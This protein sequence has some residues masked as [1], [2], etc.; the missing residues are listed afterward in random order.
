MTTNAFLFVWDQFGI[1]SIVPITQYE[2]WDKDNLIRILKEQPTLPNPLNGIIRS[3]VLR[4]KVNNQRNYEIYAVD[5]SEE[6][7]LVFWKHKWENFPQE[8]VNIIRERGHKIFSN[9][10]TRTPI[11]I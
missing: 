9:I 4:A 5:C 8:C 7:D 1:E 3:L 2:H 11:I 6:M 10:E